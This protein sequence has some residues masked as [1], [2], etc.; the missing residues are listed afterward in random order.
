MPPTDKLFESILRGEHTIS[1]MRNKDL[2]K[3]LP[4]MSPGQV[5]R[6]NKRL[7][8][9]GMIKRVGRTYKY[10]ITKL[11][12]RVITSGV[13]IRQLVLLPQLAQTTPG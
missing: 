11:G 7:R 13:K 3:H 2:R 6:H 4:D 5:S 10:Y 12:R 9:H 1:G 8:T